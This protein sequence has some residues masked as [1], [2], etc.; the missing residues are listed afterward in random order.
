MVSSNLSPDRPFLRVTWLLLLAVALAGVA[1]VAFLPPFEGFDE[2]NHFS[3]IQ[4]MADTGRL[5]RYGV[6][7]ASQDK[8]CP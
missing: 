3:Y 5:P 2:T 7:K 1:H 8:F 6:D 4:Q